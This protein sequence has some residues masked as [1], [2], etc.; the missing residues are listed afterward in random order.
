M[1][2]TVK[3]TFRQCKAMAMCVSL[4][5][6]MFLVVALTL[7]AWPTTGQAQTE[8]LTTERLRASE[9]VII[10]TSTFGTTSPLQIVGLPAKA[11]ETNCVWV[12]ASGNFK[13]GTCSTGTVTSV[14][15][16]LP[17]SEFIVTNSP[18]TTSGILTGAW[19][20]QN[21][22][23]VFARGSGTGV[24]SFQ[25]LAKSHLP[26]VTV[27]TD[28]A[29]TWGNFA[30]SMGGTLAV[31]GNTAL[32]TLS[33][34]AL[35]TLNSASVTTTLGVAGTATFTGNVV[36]GDAAT[37]TVTFT[38]RLASGLTWTTDNTFDLGASGA[39]RPRD[40]FL[41][42]N[43]L[44]GGTLGVT[45]ATSL[46]TLSTSGLATLNS[47]SVTTS[48]TVGTTLGVTGATTLGGNLAVNSGTITSTASD[49]SITPA[50]TITMGRTTRWGSGAHAQSTAYTSQTTGWRVSD[51]GEADFRYLF[52]DEM[53]ARVFIAD[54][55]QALAGGQIIAKSVAMVGTTFTCPAAGATSTL[56]VRDLPSAANMAAFQASDW[57]V[58]RNFSRAGGSLTISECVGTVSA[59]ADGTGGNDGLQSWTFTRGTGGCSGAMTASTQVAV[60][61]LA[62][63]YGTTGNGYHEI[64][65]ID[66]ANALNS[67]YSQTVTWA[68]CPVAANRVVRS[69][70]G[71]LRGI[72]GIANEFG[73]IAG[74][75]STGTD[76]QFIRASNS[77][78]ELHGIDLSMWDGSAN[79]VIVLRRAGGN[80][81]FALGA[82]GAPA[83]YL[84][85]STNGI[86]MGKDGAAYKLRIGQTSAGGALTSGLTWDG[87]TLNIIGAITVTG[88]NALTTSS[89]Y[90]GSDA[91]GGVATQATTITSQGTLATANQ[92]A[93]AT[94]VSGVPD[95]IRTGVPAGMNASGDLIR[96]INANTLAS[97]SPTVTGLHLTPTHMGYWDQA[98]TSWNAYIQS[99]GYFFF[100]NAAA[101]SAT[102]FIQWDGTNL[103]IR[104]TLQVEGGQSVLSTA[105]TSAPGL[106]AGAATLAANTQ[107]VGTVSASNVAGWAR[108]GNTTFIDGGQIFTG[109]VTATQLVSD[110]SITNT[111]RSP[112]ATAFTTGVGF[113]LDHNAG[114]PRLRVGDPAGMRFSW[115]GSALALG[116]TESL[117]TFDTVN[118]LRI[119]SG[120]VVRFR[121]TPAG[122]F[123]IEDSNAV[124]VFTINAGGGAEYS[125]HLTLGT[126]GGLYQGTGTFGTPTT[127]L[128]L[129]NDAGIG[130]LATYSGGD[131]Q[132]G[133][134]T[135]GTLTAGAGNVKLNASGLSVTSA[136]T[137]FAPIN[138][139]RFDNADATNGLLGLYGNAGTSWKGLA[140]LA[141]AKQAGPAYTAA[142]LRIQALSRRIGGGENTTTI[143]AESDGDNVPDNLIDLA[144]E[145]GGGINLYTTTPNSL[146]NTGIH[147]WHGG[148]RLLSVIPF[149]PA[150]A[151]AYATLRLS[152][153]DFV[154]NPGHNGGLY[155]NWD[156]NYNT[157]AGVFAR[158]NSANS[159]TFNG[160]LV[161]G[162]T[163]ANEIRELTN[164][165][166][167]TCGSNTTLTVRHG[168]IIGCS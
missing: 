42:R 13:S 33:T 89:N 39:N 73:F 43:A 10:G 51:I 80:P 87:T 92:A 35:A 76:R 133:F 29:N 153:V 130:R 24:P 11:G 101:P 158:L 70:M 152:G 82:G 91:P 40:L 145:Y 116:R 149:S 3:D 120:G 78:L 139:Y 67:P 5:S 66:G 125:R 110:L 23:A 17:T 127:G 122:V 20:N 16:A 19:A 163:N 64:N 1:N 58:V 124:P 30:Q 71:N 81:Y 134:D 21:Q 98:T 60:D 105:T 95:S 126:N 117:M 159:T 34:S 140:L 45:G 85:A 121:V 138:G 32:S 102:R 128:K 74:T 129:W 68:T 27:F 146:G 38:S 6:L 164:A 28:Q 142:R 44:V 93:W 55:E 162:A 52:V 160:V 155:L 97:G 50:T 86:W 56:W 107:N 53:H 168:L 114:T 132:V 96:R 109:T 143:R 108:S 69:R 90:A 77:A 144:V 63:D 83:G 151:T 14:G 119:L 123:S 72:T 103:T 54:L 136:S 165:V 61:S 84:T 57:V 47:A 113:W 36:V 37:D 99:N 150:A 46:S 112:A 161:R 65:A 2:A 8:T 59:Y 31:T 12:D 79:P 94:Q 100:G 118:G 9:R 106:T 15:L 4:R 115:D 18:V 157:Y 22:W 148:T 48:A 75:Y 141:E 154:L 166:T 62:I 156:V 41:A 167:G 135:T 104:G 7:G 26:A 88:G 25:M 147:Y 49:L 131:L 137:G 111:I